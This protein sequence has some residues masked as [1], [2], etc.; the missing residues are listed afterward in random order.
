MIDTLNDQYEEFKIWFEKFV[1]NYLNKKVDQ[2]GFL[3]AC[4]VFLLYSENYVNS[5]ETD[6]HKFV[7]HSKRSKTS[8]IF[9]EE[10]IKN[11]IISSTALKIYSIFSY[12]MGLRLTEDNH[13][14]VYNK[15]INR[16]MNTDT[17][18]KI[19]QL[20][21]SRASGSS[22]N[23][24]Y[25]W[26]MIKVNMSETPESFSMQV[27]NY[28][29]SHLY[30]GLKPENN[31]VAY[32]VAVIDDKLMWL[33]KTI[34]NKKIIYGEMFGDGGEIHNNSIAKNTLH[35]KCCNDTLAK[36]SAASLNLLRT[37]YGLSEEQLIE[38]N[39]RLD[40]MIMI[41]PHM[42]R[43][44]IPIISKVLDIPV[45]FLEKSP[46]KHIV[47]T[48]ILM[49]ECGREILLPRFPI[50]SEYLLC[51]SKTKFLS[52]DKSAYVI[53]SPEYAINSEAS[54]FGFSSKV[55][56]FQ[57]CSCICG[58]LNACRKHMIYLTD[59][60]PLTKFNFD[61]LESE[62]AAFYGDLYSDKLN[63]EF[64]KMAIVADKY[65]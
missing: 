11:I 49:Y 26:D 2:K 62:T 56:M 9:S 16:L 37:E 8:L 27:F 41:Y 38:V 63:G 19:Y 32:I 39:E 15:L 50:L 44:T 55:I 23:N 59:G 36:A 24:K 48:G 22:V 30:P 61:C 34:I 31:P 42:S 64:E 6:Y 21:R 10:E 65:F 5:L 1:K 4:D 13:K 47:L 45:T 28:M 40:E 43:F 54:I 29:M 60:K 20:I 53:K 46:P 57:V 35:I 51:T 25:V 17:V 18:D 52:N 58:V 7:N 12:D 14:E 3:K 33:M